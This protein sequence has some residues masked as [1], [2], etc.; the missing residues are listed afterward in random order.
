MTFAQFRI[1]KNPIN[2]CLNLLKIVSYHLIS[3][4]MSMIIIGFM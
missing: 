3:L 2:S 1:L 4:L